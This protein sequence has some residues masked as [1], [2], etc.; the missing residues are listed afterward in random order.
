[1]Y[2]RWTQLSIGY[3]H[4]FNLLETS[5]IINDMNNREAAIYSIYALDSCFA[6]DENT[7]TLNA[8]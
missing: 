6:D 4:K 5:S 7:N 1:M 3:R 8:Y 2:L